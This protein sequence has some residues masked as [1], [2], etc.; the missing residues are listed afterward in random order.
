MSQ[1]VIKY[2]SPTRLKVL[3]YLLINCPIQDYGIGCSV[4]KMAKDLDLSVTAVRSYLVELERYNLLI[5]KEQ[6]KGS[7][8]PT[9]FYSL[10]ENALSLFPKSYSEFSLQLLNKVISNYGE[11]AAKE[12]LVDIG[13]EKAKAIQETIEAEHNIRLDEVSFKE[14][15]E[16]ITRVFQENQKFPILVD[17]EGDYFLKNFNCLLYDIVQNQPIACIVDETC[18]QELVGNGAE[19][20]NCLSE[21]DHYCVYRFDKN[22]RE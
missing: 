4:K 13:K 9:R 6:K 5:Q 20:I 1:E 21:G 7:G 2:F 11:E 19:K 14:K 17:D 3:Q 10:H 18:L 12:I 22:D 15:L 8:R 16:L